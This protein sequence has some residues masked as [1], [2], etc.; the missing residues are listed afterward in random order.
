MHGARVH[1]RVGPQS[2][3]S[4]QERAGRA[5]RMLQ[6]GQS[7]A[8]GQV[9]VF[10]DLHGLEQCLQARF[11]RR[12]AAMLRRQQCGQRRLEKH[13]E[14]ERR[15]GAGAAQAESASG[16]G[17]VGRAVAKGTF[18][19]GT[20]PASGQLAPQQWGVQPCALR[21]QC[22]CARAQQ[23]ETENCAPMGVDASC[24]G[25][26]AHF[27]VDAFALEQFER[28]AGRTQRGQAGKIEAQRKQAAQQSPRVHVA[29]AAT[30]DE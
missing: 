29:V 3:A 13:R 20:A 22:S 4:G 18:G 27:G 17:A 9:G 21:H 23:A 19:Q 2:A 12:S 26:H 24:G 30:V 8:I 25:K 28:R 15:L 7:A 16:D 5:L 10:E 1:Q 14:S 11:T 6:S